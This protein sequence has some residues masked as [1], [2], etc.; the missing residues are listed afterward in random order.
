MK[1]TLLL[2]TLLLALFGASALL[3]APAAP[4]PQAANLE[5][6]RQA[7]FQPTPAEE[8]TVIVCFVLATVSGAGAI[9]APFAFAWS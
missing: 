4:A 2:C 5:Q 7:I 3:A 1:R 9:A 8:A 6:L